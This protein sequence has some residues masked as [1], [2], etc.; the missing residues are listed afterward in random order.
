MG[1]YSILTYVLYLMIRKMTHLACSA[2]S[3]QPGFCAQFRVVVG[4]RCL[5]KMLTHIHSNRLLVM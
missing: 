3:R 2:F 1:E 4:G 5:L